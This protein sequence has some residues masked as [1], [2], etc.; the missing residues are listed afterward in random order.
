MSVSTG[1]PTFRSPPKW[2]FGTGK[3]QGRPGVG[4]VDGREGFA[5]ETPGRGFGPL[6]R[7]VLLKQPLLQ[8]TR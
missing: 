3:E 6:P 5:D 1:G 7:M 8:K 2:C 4:S